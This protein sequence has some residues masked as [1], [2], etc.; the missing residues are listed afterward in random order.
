MKTLQKG[1]KQ[2]VLS[3]N[4]KGTTGKPHPIMMVMA[5]GVVR[6]GDK[7][8]LVRRVKEPFKGQLA[9]PGGHL[10]KDDV[11]LRYT[12]FRELTEELGPVANVY[13]F[14]LLTVLDTEGR[15]PR[16]EHSMSVVFIAD[17][18]KFLE[19]QPKPDEVSE[20]VIKRI[21]DLR[22]EDLAFDH[23]KVLSFLEK[24]N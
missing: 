23:A 13:D 21:Q 15:D 16:Y 14:K 4:R 1:R 5:D 12:C 17:V 22:A 10:E 3:K 6:C 19:F 24:E 9:F 2:K 7:V 8:L 20:V 11:S 18:P